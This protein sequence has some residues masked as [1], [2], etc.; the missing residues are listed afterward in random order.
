MDFELTVHGWSNNECGTSN[1]DNRGALTHFSVEK[2]KPFARSR[3]KG[4]T[5]KRIADL[6]KKSEKNYGRTHRRTGIADVRSRIGARA[7]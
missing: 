5:E 3:I 2:A 4:H 1:A 7:F 6:T